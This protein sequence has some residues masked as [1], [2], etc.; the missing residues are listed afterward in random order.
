MIIYI[1]H[2]REFDFKTELYQPLKDSEFFK[3]HTLVFPHERADAFVDGKELFKSGKCD[4]VLAEVSFPATG[5]GIELGWASDLNIKIICF[6]KKGF[7]KSGS[8]KLV[9][10][11]FLE[12]E[13]KSDMIEKLSN[14]LK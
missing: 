9:S 3:E 4:L 1:S 5:Q 7:K 14:Y 10:K 11:D 12:Y 13:N 6:Y 8:L 2:S